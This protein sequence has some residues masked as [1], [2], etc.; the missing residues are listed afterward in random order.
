MESSERL[1]ARVRH[2]K[3]TLEAEAAEI[4]VESA[5]ECEIKKSESQKMFGNLHKSAKYAIVTHGG[6]IR[7]FALLVSGLPEKMVES[8]P[9][10]A[11]N[12]NISNCSVSIFDFKPCKGWSIDAIGI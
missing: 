1:K 4:A 11:L 3:E 9:A 8:L 5:L 6:V 12:L 10:G 7:T 2:F